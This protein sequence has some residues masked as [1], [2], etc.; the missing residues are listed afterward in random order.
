[1]FGN[2][3]RKTDHATHSQDLVSINGDGNLGVVYFKIQR[4]RDSH[5]LLRI[6]R[7]TKFHEGVEP[8]G[9]FVNSELAQAAA[10]KYKTEHTPDVLTWADQSTGIVV[11]RIR[12]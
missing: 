4:L 6:T 2:K 10:E 7:I 9:S 12:D 3:A 1:M 5:R 8:L 11:S